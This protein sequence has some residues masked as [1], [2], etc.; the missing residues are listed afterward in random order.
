MVEAA[1]SSG[2]SPGPS[3]SQVFSA[4]FFLL[5]LFM[6]IRA[7][8]VTMGSLFLAT[9]VSA[10]A[11]VMWNG[12]EASALPAWPTGAGETAGR[13]LSAEGLARQLYGVVREKLEL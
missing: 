13:A 7:K 10:S 11:A 2:L 9:C 4:C 8:P 12:V 1:T 6:L 5:G 3:Q